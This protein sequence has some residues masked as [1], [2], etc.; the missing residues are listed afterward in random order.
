LRGVAAQVEI[1]FDQFGFHQQ[2]AAFG[3]GHHV[4]ARIQQRRVD[5]GQH[6]FGQAPPPRQAARPAR[7]T[8]RRILPARGTRPATGRLLTAWLRRPAEI[9]QRGFAFAFRWW[10]RY[11]C[12]SIVVPG[13]GA[14][15]SPRRTRTVFHAPP[16]IAGLTISS[17]APR[18]IEHPFD[19]VL[20]ESA[21]VKVVTGIATPQ[22]ASSVR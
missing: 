5:R 6:L 8:H 11:G 17:S 22:A 18:F 16:E 7:D 10:D 20:P 21:S 4:D 9:Q 15:A 12:T 1:G 14:M 3:I 13:A 19:H 2:P